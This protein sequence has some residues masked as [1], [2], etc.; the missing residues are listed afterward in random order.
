MESA[1]AEEINKVACGGIFLM[2]STSCLE[3]CWLPHLL[4]SADHN[5]WY[6]QWDVMCSNSNCWC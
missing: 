3:A 4:W 5:K 2:I 6:V 1:T